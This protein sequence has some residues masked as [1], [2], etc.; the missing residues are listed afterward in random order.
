MT[1]RRKT[2]LAFGAMLALGAFATSGCGG[3]GAVPVK[4]GNGR[5]LT[6]PRILPGELDARLLLEDLPSRAIKLGAGPVTVVASGEAVEGER[7]GAFVE[8]PADQCLL[9]YAR[10]SSSLDDID[11]AAFADEGNPIATDE[12]PDAHPTILLCPPHPERVYLAVHAASG[13]GLVALAAQLVP[14]DRAAEVGRVLGARGSRGEGP[15]P[16]DAWPGLED[17]VRVHRAVLGGTW[18][19][20]RRV[21]LTLDARSTAFVALPLEAGQ[22]VDAVIVPD[23]DVSMVDVEAMDGEGRVIARARDGE[24]IRTITIC[25]QIAFT[26]SLAVRPHV[27]SGLAAVVIGRTKGDAAKGLTAHAQ[28][29]WVGSPLTLE[30]ARA[31]KNAELAKAGYLAA[32]TPTNGTLALGRR[33]MLPIDVAP[34]ASCSRVDVVAGTPLA[35]VEAA[36]WDPNGAWVNGND[37]SNGA[38]VFV[39]GRAK[40]QLELETRGRPG[41]FTVLVRAER[42]K[43]PAFV[44]R[45][46]AASRMLTRAASGPGMLHEGTALPTKTFTLD[47]SRRVSYT[48]A[49]PPGQCLRVAVGVEGD[50]AGVELRLFDGVTSDEL[51]R[52]SAE[53]RVSGR[54]CASATMPRQV[55]VEIRGGTGRLEA[56]VGERLSTGG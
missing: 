12:A 2:A 27:G 46:L 16:A 30:A 54:A 7:L 34:A 53:M 37:G 35:L 55:R 29:A 21:A 19:E 41:P 44:T 45:P 11:V 10:S 32:A 47:P 43:D 17:H 13:E 51:D 48:Q 24:K 42:W 31:A 49:V 56:V 23:D 28:V 38:T 4:H 18:E 5:P 9:G 36:V 40:A 6:A 20:L 26:G 22:C 8:V 25:S 3:H 50:G 15:R 39:C 33:V 52:E 14:R 1:R